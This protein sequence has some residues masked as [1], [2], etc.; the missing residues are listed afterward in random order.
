MQKTDESMGSEVCYHSIEFSFWFSKI[1]ECFQWMR[2][3]ISAEVICSLTL[4]IILLNSCQR[5]Y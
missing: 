3:G 2:L 5:D 1:N 4:M